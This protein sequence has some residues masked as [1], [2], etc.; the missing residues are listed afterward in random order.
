M[1]KKEEWEH[2]DLLT[3]GVQGSNTT[4]HLDNFTDDGLQFIK[5]ETN[6]TNLA[7]GIYSRQADG[8]AQAK[9][10][11]PESL[12]HQS[13]YFPGEDLT[14][15]F[16]GPN[17][18]AKALIYFFA[19]E[20]LSNQ[21]ADMSFG[22]VVENPTFDNGQL[23]L[24]ED[25][26]ITTAH[27]LV[28][29][30][31]EINGNQYLNESMRLRVS[32]ISKNQL[33]TVEAYREIQF[34]N[35]IWNLRIAIN[36]YNG[37]SLTELV[38]LEGPIIARTGEIADLNDAMNEFNLLLKETGAEVEESLSKNL[39]SKLYPLLETGAIESV[40]PG[41]ESAVTELQDAFNVGRRDDDKLDFKIN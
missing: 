19:D 6:G 9:F 10:V 16:K 24:N 27:Y 33:I 13:A 22:I 36:L 39:V 14:R 15:S 23:Q 41:F 2:Y 20:I 21:D 32:C 1:E 5:I 38:S 8:N 40:I 7:F 31:S 30:M 12:R 37:E 34:G 18:R 3:K 35:E 29:E 28:D 25:C 26:I 4:I 17:E 11:M